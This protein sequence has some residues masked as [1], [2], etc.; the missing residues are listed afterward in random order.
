MRFI[1]ILVEVNEIFGRIFFVL[2][3]LSFII[4]F[5]NFF[6]V[7]MNEVFFEVKDLVN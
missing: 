2:L 5:M 7:L 1:N 6:I 3:L 4:L